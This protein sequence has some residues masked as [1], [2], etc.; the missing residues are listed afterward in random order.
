MK[1]SILIYTIT[2]LLTYQLAIINCIEIEEATN[3]TE[4]YFISPHGLG[5]VPEVNIALQNINGHVKVAHTTRNV[6]TITY[7]ID[8]VT[9]GMVYNPSKQNVTVTKT[10]EI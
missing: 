8:N 2:L 6:S 1:I 10:D 4:S 7:I 5:R 3:G 9:L